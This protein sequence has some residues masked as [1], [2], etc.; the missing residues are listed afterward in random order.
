MSEAMGRS[1]SK[2]R[3]FTRHHGLREQRA[4]SRAEGRA[5]DGPPTRTMSPKEYGVLSGVM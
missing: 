1:L 5:R 3:V 4:S 2:D